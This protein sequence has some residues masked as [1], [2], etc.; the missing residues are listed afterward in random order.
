MTK[1]INLRVPVNDGS[2]QRMNH[3]GLQSLTPNC[4]SYCDETQRYGLS[5]LIV[6]GTMLALAA[7]FS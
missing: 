4:E 6:R 3:H 7:A 2:A 1:Q 5:V